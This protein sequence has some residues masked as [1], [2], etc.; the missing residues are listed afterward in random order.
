MTGYCIGHNYALGTR[1]CNQQLYY[2][3]KK[4]GKQKHKKLKQS[5]FAYLLK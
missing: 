2:L 1:E 4:Y 5:K 3:Q